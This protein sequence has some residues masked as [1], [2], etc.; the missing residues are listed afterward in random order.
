MHTIAESLDESSEEKLSRRRL[1]AVSWIAIALVATAVT[2]FAYVHPSLSGLGKA[3]GLPPA[4]SVSTPKPPLLSNDYLATYYFVSP[5]LGWALVGEGRPAPRLWVFKTA[6]GARHWQSQL[7]GFAPVTSFGS[8]QLQFFD[9]SHGFIA[10]GDP[11]AVYRTSDGGD[12][13]ALLRPPD[14]LSASVD[15]SDPR[16]GWIL[17]YGG[18]SEHPVTRLFSTSDAGD[19]WT[20]LPQVPTLP[21]AFARRGGLTANIAFRGPTEGWLGGFQAAGRPTVYSSI[22]GGMTWQPHLLPVRAPGV[23]PTG[24]GLSLAGEA[25]VYVI[26]GAGVLAASADD[27]GNIVGLTSFD[28]GSTW[29]RL[30]PPPGETTSYD[31]VFQDTFHWWAMRYGTL[32]KSSDAGQSWKEVAQE[33]DEWD[34]L[35]GVIDAKHAWAQMVVVFP[36][37]NPPQ[38]TGLAMSSDGGLRWTPVNVPRPV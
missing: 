10:I 12:H 13:W 30:A 36:N 5:S 21:G 9:R 33:M 22:D 35:P 1:R 15:F 26:P 18:S 6:D 25:S 27:Q 17:G 19:T 7:A 34:Y 4:A 32:F 11:L 20:L 38:G 37:S 29:R 8:L 16:H 2:A 23:P 14:L 3:V 28:G 24:K 31:Y